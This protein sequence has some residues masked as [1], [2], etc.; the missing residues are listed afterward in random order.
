[1]V[2]LFG[3]LFVSAAL[4][5]SLH[6]SHPRRKLVRLCIGVPAGL[7]LV[8][9]SSV[10]LLYEWN[11]FSSVA[12]VLNGYRLFNIAR[13][14][15]GRMHPL[16]LW[17]VTQRTTYWLIAAQLFILTL[18]AVWEQ[19][20]VSTV[21]IWEAIIA[22][23]LLAALV[24]AWSTR[25]HAVRI[26]A[27]ANLKPVV[28]SDLP[29]LTVAIPARNETEALQACIES[30]LA[31][32][33][34]K[35]EI[36]VLDDCS[37]STRTPE[38]IRSYAHKG[39]RFLQGREPQPN[40]LAKNQ[41]YDDLAAA[42]SGELLVFMGV[43]IRLAPDSLRRLV[44]YAV[45]KNKTMLC[46]MP[47]NTHDAGSAALVQPVRYL[48][49]L[50]LPRKLFKRPPVL[51]SLWLIRRQALQ[52]AGGFAAAARM[53]IPETYFARQQLAHDGY[54][55]V[56]GGTTYGITSEKDIAAQ[57]RTA[58]RVAYPQLHRRPE[59]VAC[60]TIVCVT[61]SLT[62][63]VLTFQ[64]I[65][66]RDLPLAGLM[67]GVLVW[68]VYGYMYWT[69]L[70]LAYGR[71]NPLSLCSFPL[72]VLGYVALMQYSMY[73]YEFSEV[74]WKGRN[75]CLPVMHVIPRLPSL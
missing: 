32:D 66:G 31:S 40:W 12:V 41:A 4:E 43:D 51:S 61:W 65:L 10:W 71:A 55:F 74:L 7:F 20:H 75:V 9:V 63:L 42:A 37:Q 30:L 5:L 27:S 2:F 49:E 3:L 24:M 16:Y 6:L 18:W 72:A 39:V 17:R 1:M 13:A 34:P 25:R 70:V 15:K 38:I 53:I 47:R 11:V 69:V 67:A 46:V 23:Q 19:V 52:Q 35:L 64:A 58:I 48:W 8:Y 68:L 26:R 60:I 73:K 62:L 57:R 21:H 28:S 50:A 54:S 56:A 14:I 22:M 44:T 29:S 45:Q 33:Y 36:L 59:L